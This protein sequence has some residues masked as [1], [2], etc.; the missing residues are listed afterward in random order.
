MDMNDAAN[1]GRALRELIS[2]CHPDQKD[3]Y[4]YDLTKKG[5]KQMIK[6]KFPHVL[7]N[8]LRA[9]G[10]HTIAKMLPRLC[11]AAGVVNPMS[12]TPH[13]LR[14]YYITLLANNPALNPTDV[15]KRARHNNIRSQEAYIRTTDN[16]QAAAF[17][18]L[19]N[20]YAGTNDENTLNEASTVPVMPAMCP[21]PAMQ[22]GMMPQQAIQPTRLM[23]AQALNQHVAYDIMLQHARPRPAT[24]ADLQARMLYQLDQFQLQ[25]Q[26]QQQQQNRVPTNGDLLSLMLQQHQQQGF[27]PFQG[28]MP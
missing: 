13:L 14:A 25:Q 2:H 11:L 16:A 24:D 9:I 19:R 5:R 20:P 3:V 12:K 26:L 6:D 22:G 17:D 10:K 27:N 15:A 21:L 8:P 1:I 7:Y 28:H 18:T 4:C 23:P